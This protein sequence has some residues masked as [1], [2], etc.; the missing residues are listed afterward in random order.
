MSVRFDYDQDRVLKV[1]VWVHGRDDLKTE[2][3]LARDRPR[4]A[5]EREEEEKEEWREMLEGTINAARH[6]LSQYSGYMDPGTASKMESDIQRA[7]RAFAEGNKIEGRR[8]MNALH[9]AIMGSGVASQLFI[10]ERA[11]DGLGPEEANLIREAVRELRFAHEAGDREQVEKIS[12]A[13]QLGVARIFQRRAGQ[14]EV[15]DQDWG[16]LLKD[17]GR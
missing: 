16:G 14:T 5:F 15:A 2:Q 10:A 13:L 12:M 17:I 11:M 8:V 4:A 9:R 7:E 6:F 1:T 3:T